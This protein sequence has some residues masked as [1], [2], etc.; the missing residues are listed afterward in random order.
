[1]MIRFVHDSTQ[2]EFSLQQAAEYICQALIED[3]N[4]LHLAGC[5]DGNQRG[6]ITLP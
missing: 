1:M 3:T 4:E 5:D 2:D 6:D